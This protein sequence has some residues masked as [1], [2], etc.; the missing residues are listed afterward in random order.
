MTGW[1]RGDQL[2]EIAAQA[3]ISDSATIGQRCRIYP[4]VV[5][6]DDVVI[7]DDVTIYPGCHI[8]R[9][10]LATASIVMAPETSGNPTVIGRGTVI[11]ANSVIYRGV[12]LG[13]EV[14]ISDGAQLR[15][16]VVVE[17]GAIIGGHVTV[18]PSARI[19]KNA[20]ILDL[21]HVTGWADVGEGVYWSVGVISA[22][23]NS[24]DR[25]GPIKPPILDAGVRIGLGTTILPGVHMGEG[26]LAA[27]GSVVTKSVAARETVRGLPARPTRELVKLLHPNGV[28]P[29]DPFAQ[30]KADLN[31][32]LAAGHNPYEILDAE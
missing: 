25:G 2:A 15:E 18:A 24:L 13:E 16:N 4:F 30:A 11:G 21:S 3:V 32:A 7:G 20:R 1:R 28:P 12:F 23:D 8:G 22:N 6:D 14:L 27:A 17:G 31:T 5:I 9:K 29:E 19:R 26:S 10:P